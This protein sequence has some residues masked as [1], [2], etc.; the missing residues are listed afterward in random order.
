MSQSSPFDLQA[1][2]EY[3]ELGFQLVPC[4][5]CGSQTLDHHWICRSCGWEYDSTTGETE[6]SACN[7]A[8][9]AD[10]RKETR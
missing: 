9:V 8:T 7:K 6:Y 5:V 2:R 1:T 4:P 3:R 10:Y